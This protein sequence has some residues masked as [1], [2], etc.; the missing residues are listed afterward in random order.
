MTSHL[1]VLNGEIDTMDRTQDCL[2]DV[3]VKISCPADS[4]GGI[5]AQLCVYAFRD[6]WFVVYDMGGCHISVVID[7]DRDQLSLQ[8]CMDF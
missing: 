6:V 5:C 2:P 7:P 3:S 4:G 1:G 8:L